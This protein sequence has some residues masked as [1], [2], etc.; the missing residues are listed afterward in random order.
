MSN[1]SKFIKKLSLFLKK[2]NKV[3]SKDHVNLNNL[4]E[5]GLLFQLDNV[6]KNLEDIKSENINLLKKHNNNYIKNNIIQNKNLKKS[7]KNLNDLCQ[8]IK[9]MD[10]QGCENFIEEKMFFDRSIN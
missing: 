1:K 3:K 5:E 9:C 4:N 10:S 2:S 6:N 8:E 7:Y